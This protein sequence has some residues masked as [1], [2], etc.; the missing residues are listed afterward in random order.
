MCTDSDILEALR[1]P[2]LS[3]KGRDRYLG[4][5]CRSFIS[6]GQEAKFWSLLRQAFVSPQSEAGRHDLCKAVLFTLL[7]LSGK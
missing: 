3:G 7:K 1:M 6:S 2:T 4:R 5:N